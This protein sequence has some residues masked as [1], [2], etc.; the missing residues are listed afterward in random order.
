MNFTGPALAVFV[1]LEAGAS[2]LFFSMASACI[3]MSGRARQA[4][5]AGDRSSVLVSP[6]HLEHA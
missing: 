2:R 5:G 1:G 4:S 3:G 6:V